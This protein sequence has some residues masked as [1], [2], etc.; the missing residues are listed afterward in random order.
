MAN[1]IV[2]FKPRRK[3]SRM[4]GR[5]KVQVDQLLLKAL[6]RFLGLARNQI[7]T[8][9]C[10]EIALDFLQQQ[11]ELVRQWALVKLT[12]MIIQT[13]RAARPA[14]PDPYQMLLF[15]CSLR[16][17]VPLGSGENVRLQWAT[18]EMIREG[19]G[20]LEAAAQNRIRQDPRLAHLKELLGAMAPLERA[21]PALTVQRYVELAAAGVE[22]GVKR[23]S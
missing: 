5:A 3:G 7:P 9:G 20:V 1:T 13:R 6:T 11:P 17:R 16:G 8:R 4:S 14:R 22:A 21:Y 18:I 10:D 23:G 15:G 2:A 19:I 12:R